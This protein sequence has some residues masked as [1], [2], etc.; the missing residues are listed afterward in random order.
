[1]KQRFVLFVLFFAVLWSPASAAAAAQ[2]ELALPTETSTVTV[3]LEGRSFTAIVVRPTEGEP[4]GYPVVGFA[5]GL[6]TPAGRYASTLA[7]MAARGYVVIA[8]NTQTGLV[9]SQGQLA[10]D[11][12]LSIRW[13]QSAEPHA[14]PTLD[15]VT[16]HSMG[17]GAALVAADRYPAIDSVATL[18][19]AS[20]APSSL[21]AS[22]GI[23]APA[24]YVVGTHDLIVPAARTWGMFA[25]KPA[26]A[27][28]SAI[29]GGWHCGFLDS[30][31]AFGL[32]CDRGPLSRAAQLDVTATL[33]GDWLDHTLRGT[34]LQAAPPGVVTT[35]K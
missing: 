3:A 6:A 34:V 17:G 8:P 24:L 29:T 35:S 4:G 25:S 15:A 23:T 26:P 12:W 31:A 11:L 21:P 13:A 14:H 20:T 16:G 9:S 1:M 10:A 2:T 18:G 22:A 33:L 7:A 32:G 27:H 5:H 19:A 28:W 30:P